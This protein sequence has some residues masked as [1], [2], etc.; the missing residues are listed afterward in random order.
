MNVS[1][2]VI[3]CA[4]TSR[5]LTLLALIIT[6]VGLLAEIIGVIII[7]G[8]DYQKA[9][10]K[11]ENIYKFRKIESIEQL[12]D[13]IYETKLKLRDRD[14]FSS[15]GAQFDLTEFN[16]DVLKRI[17]FTHGE[18]TQEIENVGFTAMTD[19]P[20]MEDI[21][22]T[23]STESEDDILF[24]HTEIQNSIQ[25]AT[26]QVFYWYGAISV[27]FGFILMFLATILEI[28]TYFM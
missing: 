18:Q 28:G 2:S 16:E 19:D 17:V 1:T 23:I 27:L 24:S 3:N 25:K 15:E 22:L 13:T 20:T 8:G 12:Q 26:R 7:L 5:Q 4:P 11:L 21:R 6:F 9:R 14:D 10:I